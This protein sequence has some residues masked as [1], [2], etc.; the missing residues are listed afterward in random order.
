[1]RVFGPLLLGLLA[2]ASAAMA[3]PQPLSR[4]QAPA[5]PVQAPPPPPPPPPRPVQSLAAGGLG[6]GLVGL[7]PIRPLGGGLVGLAA[8][9]DPAPQCRGTCGKAHNLCSNGGD[10]DCDTRWTQCVAACRTG[11]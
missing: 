10:D 3:Q 11:R 1:M 6:G 5:P 4:P 8:A 9:G 7:Q 2:L